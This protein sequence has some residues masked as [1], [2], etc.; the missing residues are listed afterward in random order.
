[1]NLGSLNPRGRNHQAAFPVSWADRKWIIWVVTWLLAIFFTA[2]SSSGQVFSWGRNTYGQLNI[3]ANLTNAAAICSGYQHCLALKSDSSLVA[4][5]S[6]TNGQN[7]VPV[8]ISKNVVAIK[9]GYYHNLAQL[10]DGTLAAWGAGQTNAGAGFDYGQSL[11]PTNLTN[12]LTIS[13]GGY[14][15]LALLS[16]HTVAVWGRN[17][18]GETNMPSGLTN[19]AAIS[20][21]GLHGLVL[22]GDGTVVGWG[23]NTYGQCTVPAGLS[24]VVA[25]VAGDYNSYAIRSD[26]TMAVWGDNTVGQDNI[27]AGMSNFVAATGGAYHS[28]AIQDNGNPMAWGTYDSTLPV[29]VTNAIALHSG[30]Y[31]GLGLTNDGTP[32][33]TFQ[34][35]SRWIFSGNDTALR[36]L[37][38]GSP[39]MSYQW[40]FNGTPISDATNAQLVLPAMQTNQAGLYSFM[41]S[42]GISSVA[43][44]NATVTVIQQPPILTAQPGSLVTARYGAATFNSA[45]IGSPPLSFQWQWNGTTISGA[46]NPVLSYAHVSPAQP[47]NYSVSVS[48]QFGVAVSTNAYLTLLAVADNGDS[49]YN[50]S[51]YSVPLSLTSAVAIA[52]GSFHS[53]ALKPDNKLVVWGNNQ[54]GQTNIPAAATNIMLIGARGYTCAIVRSNGSVFMWG[55]SYVGGGNGKTNPPPSATNV[56]AIAVGD[57]HCLALRKDGTVVG[58]GNSVY[59]Q[60]NVPASATNIMAVAVGAYHSLLL[61][62]NGTL[63]AW[64]QNTSGQTNV[65]ASLTNV[66]A[67]AAAYN[68]N[69]ALKADG[70]I[71][72]W[73]D[74]STSS[75]FTNIVAIGTGYYSGSGYYAFIRADGTVTGGY[76]SGVSNATA[77]ACGGNHNLVLLGDGSPCLYWPPGALHAAH[78]GDNLSTRVLVSGSGPIY[79]Q[80][81]LN[82]TNLP[83]ATNATLTLTNVPITSAGIY[84][85]V[86]SNALGTVVSPATTLNLTRWPLLFSSTNG[87]SQMTTNGFKL[88]L[89]GLAGQGPLV[90]Y[91]SANLLDW[92]PIFTN[93]PVVGAFDFTDASATNQPSLYYRA[94]EG[95]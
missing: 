23:N 67:I 10:G 28:A 33:I 95:P 59:G 32:V 77:I 27:P 22:K 65:P 24:N 25:I 29:G 1:M 30:F 3:P 16:D 68:H 73:G 14:F 49:T 37:V 51:H 41:A 83:G 34:P 13:A 74:S 44:S 31:M 21:G 19:V 75:P 36:A 87:V 17:T 7:A 43:S 9:A 60:T 11:I 84:Q 64:G 86:I 66:I 82:G 38:S 85:C 53:M 62:S 42:N 50:Y 63:L 80:W 45:A 54:Y 78:P 76:V 81:Q 56:V 15:N 90:V 89:T 39:P 55:D 35:P 46:T 91:A 40:F 72:A 52:A 8:W 5:G 6:G 93:S 4:W 26:G 47:G 57:S 70:T 58:W 61:R 94:S 48:N 20:A 69:F 71:Y 92:L 12:V 18:Y 88:R 79:Y 2:S